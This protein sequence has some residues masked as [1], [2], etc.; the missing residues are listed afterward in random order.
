MRAGDQAR[1]AD[2]RKVTRPNL[3]VCD[4]CVCVCACV[5]QRA[6]FARAILPPLAGHASQP[7][8]APA[9]AGPFPAAAPADACAGG[10]R[11]KKKAV[12]HGAPT[13]AAGGSG[14]GAGG[15]A[16]GPTEDKAAQVR[17]GGGQGVEGHAALLRRAA[18]GAECCVA[19]GRNGLS[20][21]TCPVQL[22]GSRAAAHLRPSRLP[23]PPCRRATRQC[24]RRWRR[25]RLTTKRASPR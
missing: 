4:M 2:V 11:T 20:A 6:P 25:R 13:T 17:R 3:V 9:Q 5:S 15:A 21:P 1:S 10:R 12:R 19:R 7:E 14:G 22:M 23:Q 16:A 18:V 8:P 24:A